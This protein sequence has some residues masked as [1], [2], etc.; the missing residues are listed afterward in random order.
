MK[1]KPGISLLTIGA[2]ALIV[3]I[4][5]L[6][7]PATKEPSRKNSEILV[8]SPGNSP[9]ESN[10]SS[11]EPV[12]GSGKAANLPAE[13]ESIFADELALFLQGDA[14]AFDRFLAAITMENWREAR[15]ALKNALGS[16][17][18]NDWSSEMERFWRV[19][20]EMGGLAL[21]EE[22]IEEM[23]SDFALALK[24]WGEA[25][26]QAVFD[27][28]SSLDFAKDERIHQ[29]LEATDSRMF[30]FLDEFSDAILR[31]LFEGLTPENYTE[32]DA[33]HIDDLVN[34]FLE[35][36]PRKAMSLMREFTERIISS[37]DAEALKSWVKGFEES[38]V[39]AG[40]VQRVIESGAFDKNFAEAV[41]FA[42]SLEDPMS[43]RSALSATYAKLASGINGHD[44]N[45]TAESLIV[46]DHGP[47]R[48]SAI[49][50]FAHGLVNSDPEAA[51][52]WA[53]DVSS[54]SF[55]NVVVENISRRI[56]RL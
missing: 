30:P 50:G 7:R 5:I 47:D 9:Q 8:K 23:D 35:N 21:A 29:Y 22:M 36:D 42:W 26:P 39:Q 3:A 37:E 48:D 40:A 13:E 20:G 18:E 34:F 2:T 12:F 4:V 11:L 27:F 19:V 17:E 28:F 44:P 51:L 32:A 56:N 24:G 41:E 15:V 54:E 43:R 38:V 53:N 55:R 16:D 31:G 49:N 52:R 1:G 45:V 46:M 6:S 10:I 14:E 25:D 33:D